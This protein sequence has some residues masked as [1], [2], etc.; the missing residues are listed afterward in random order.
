MLR[1][2]YLEESTAVNHFDAATARQVKFFQIRA[3]INNREQP[4]TYKIND[5]FTSHHL[6]SR[7]RQTCHFG[8]RNFED[9]E[10]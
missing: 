7:E 3:G 6:A 8:A 1:I 2:V 9:D 4:R 5:A 10:R